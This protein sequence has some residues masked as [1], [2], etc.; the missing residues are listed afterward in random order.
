MKWNYTVRQLDISIPGYV[1]DSLQNFQHPTPTRPQHLPH[2]WTAPN[3]RSTAPQ[4][5]HPT[6]NS[7]ALNTDESINVQQVVGFFL[8]FTRSQTNNYSHTEHHLRLTIKKHPGDIKKSGAS[9]QLCGHPTLGNHL[10]PH[11]W[12]DYPH[13]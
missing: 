12:N 1:K 13:L 11:E 5:A 10:L 8:L 6:D 2:Q 3:Y 4:L 9:S 7:P